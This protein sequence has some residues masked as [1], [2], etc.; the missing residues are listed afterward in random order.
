MI[1]YTF[2]SSDISIADTLYSGQC[3]TWN[4][5]YG[6]SGV[7]CAVIDNY[8]VFISADNHNS[9]RVYCDASSLQGKPLPEYFTWYFTLDLDAAQV[10][11]E[12]FSVLFPV[13][14]DRLNNYF[15][16]KIMRQDPF[17]TMITFMCAQGIGM[18]I[19]RKQVS[20]L[21]EHY[22][23]RFDILFQDSS[24]TIYSFPSPLSLAGCDPVMLS[25]CT[26]NNRTR[27]ANIIRAS[28]AVAEGKIDFCALGDKT[29][30]LGELRSR[31]CELD[32]IGYK[33][34]DCIALFGLGRFDAFPIDTHVKQ[35]LAQWFG[36]RTALRSLTPAAY[37]KLDAEARSILKPEF[38]GYA[39]HM[40]FHCWR[41]EV[42]KLRWF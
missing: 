29:L 12:N 25:R 4:Q 40:L 28:R 36:S 23:K 31:L 2:Y 16:L 34:A 8:P 17:E 9:F 37:L 27:A 33:I 24:L 38:A 18:Q 5:P 7:H 19:I 20:L 39:G 1:A 3:F 14:W 32:G 10:F 6:H 13:L 15:R 30:P 11:P 22:G 21:A 42:K 26:N 41:K 35:Y